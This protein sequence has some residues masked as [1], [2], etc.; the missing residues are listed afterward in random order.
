MTDPEERRNPSKGCSKNPE[1]P[2]RVQN[3]LIMINIV[4][5]NI[6]SH[7][8]NGTG[9]TRSLFLAFQILFI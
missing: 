3:V 8:G 2:M 7:I 1:N 6:V 9:S 5:L 4:V